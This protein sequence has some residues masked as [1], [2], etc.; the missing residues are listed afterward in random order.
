MSTAWNQ[1]QSAD[2]PPE[3]T[4]D[5]EDYSVAQLKALLKERGLT[6]S[7]TK[8]ELIARLREAQ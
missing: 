8:D 2:V 6:T 3:I 4:A 7:G 5:L 1:W